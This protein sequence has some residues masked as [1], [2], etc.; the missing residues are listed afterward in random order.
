MKKNITV[1]MIIISILLLT[2]SINIFA[3]IYDFNHTIVKNNINYLSSDYFKGR[4]AGSIENL[5]A[6]TYI[7]NEFKKIGLL[8]F[9]NDY[10]DP[11]DSIY[12]Q[13]L[14]QDPYFKIL[15][16]KGSLVKEYK[17]GVDY[18]EEMLSFKKNHIVFSNKDYIKEGNES[19]Q[20][21]KGNNSFLFFVPEGEDLSFRSSFMAFEPSSQ[22]MYI[23]LSKNTLKE[24]KNY[25]SKEYTISCFIPFEVKETKLN[26]VTGYIKGKNSNLPPIIISAHFDHVGSDA[27]G[28]VYNGAL[29]N[30]S[31]TAFL[32]E[33]SKYISSLGTPERDIIFVAFNAEEFGLLG[34]KHFVEKYLNEIQGAKVYN[35]D[36]IG[37][38][39][40]P[41]NIMGGKGDS[42][43][44]KFV[45][46][47]V[48]TLNKEKINYN[49]TFE[50]SSDHE[51][52][53]E[54]GIDAVTFC[55]SDMSKIHTPKDDAQYI[56]VSAIDRAFNVI[57]K[58][59]IKEGFDNNIFLIYY[60]NIIIFSASTLILF[61]YIYHRINS[62]KE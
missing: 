45:R 54:N 50:P 40:V 30:A 36:M 2:Y 35:F 33:L 52:F 51:F 56:E 43:N 4:L 14:N 34:S 59:I 46:S 20:V 28:T 32:L 1:F 3:N 18:K 25:L 26:N 53:R 49:L 39:S 42:S 11:F 44:T 61:I 31:G 37:S 58:E 10:Y 5:E 9:N 38:S 57:S 48:S 17:Y 19:L 62:S 29:D 16:K 15:D 55:D 23:M 6:A 21:I 27:K 12:P 8:P 13:K 47:I 41:L 60:K 7:K 24:V 22:N